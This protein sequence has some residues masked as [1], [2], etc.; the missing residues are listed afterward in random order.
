[1]RIQEKINEYKER[2]NENLTYLTTYIED[3]QKSTYKADQLAK[4][5]AV[6]IKQANQNKDDEDSY[7]FDWI[8]TKAINFVQDLNNLSKNMR[9]IENAQIRMAESQRTIDSLKE[10][11]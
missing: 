1:M 5:L 3:L 11:L 4:E 8:R 6:A 7:Y 2:R 9:A 10:I